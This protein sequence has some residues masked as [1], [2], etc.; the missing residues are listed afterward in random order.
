M[1]S[2][3]KLML[4]DSPTNQDAKQVAHAAGVLAKYG[5]LEVHG[6]GSRNT[7]WGIDA[8][9]VITGVDSQMARE[10]VTSIVPISNIQVSALGAVSALL[11]T[12]GEIRQL[13]SRLGIS[14][15]VED[16]IMRVYEQDNQNGR[17]ELYNQL[18]REYNHSHAQKKCYTS[19]SPVGASY[20]EISLAPL[21]MLMLDHVAAVTANYIPQD[22]TLTAFCNG[23]EAI[24]LELAA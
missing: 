1:N 5:T 14:A 15:F 18:R 20:N 23:Q 16:A 17:R 4:D 10:A 2:M 12:I 7:N 3:T 13:G 11:T 24:P 8:T 19:I 9:L 21:E 6:V 22:V